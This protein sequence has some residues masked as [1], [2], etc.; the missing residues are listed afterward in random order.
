MKLHLR[1]TV[2]LHD[3]YHRREGEKYV[4]GD[5]E[6]GE[7]VF[8]T[9]AELHVMKLLQSGLAI[10]HVREL[11]TDEHAHVDVY[12]LIKKL[13]NR[14]L[15][16]R[17]DNRIVHAHSEP[18]VSL[19]LSARHFG[20]PAI[21]LLM[22]LVLLAGV[23]LFALRGSVP[24]PGLFLYQERVTL[25]LLG[26]VFIAWL[27]AFLRQLAKYGQAQWLGLPAQF[28]LRSHYAFP[29]PKAHI[30][31]ATEAQ[32]RTIVGTGLLTLVTLT[33]LAAGLAALMPTSIWSFI[34]L[35]GVLELLAE[36]FLFLDTDLARYISYHVDVHRL[37]EQTASALRAE[38]RQIV[39]GGEEQSHEHITNYAF[40][41]LFSFL[42]A[43]VTILA[44]Y[45]PIA[46]DVIGTAL[47]RFT[48][49]HPLAADASVAL[50]LLTLAL[51]WYGFATLRHHPLAHNTL[52]VNTSILAII[53]A[54]F[55]AGIM[56]A[57]WA[58]S[59]DVLLSV[60]VLYG[61]GVVLAVTF[62]RAVRLAHPFSELHGLMEG[63]VLPI[64]AACVPLGALFLAPGGALLFLHAGMLAVGMLSALAFHDAA[65]AFKHHRTYRTS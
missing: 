34:F 61:L 14:H 65:R 39:H 19:P 52:F 60:L 21:K 27:Y 64:L 42:I 29:I 6:T 55:I 40:A 44:V 56:G 13:A 49:G 12:E 16:H 24:T 28:G 57:T 17:V 59:G 38:V 30:P 54:S 48:S 31:P 15:V 10:D 46:V 33:M 3:L 1:S 43:F 5:P 4:V 58:A 37:N 22:V 26:G 50:V 45:I 36:S 2:Q 63:V 23:A 18:H 20:N 51:F 32:H 11:L 53:I 9:P 7:Y 41:Y 25:A 47:S 35:I 8:V 62:E